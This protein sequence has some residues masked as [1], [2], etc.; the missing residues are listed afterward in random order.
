M[1]IYYSWHNPHLIRITFVW[2][3]NFL[4]AKLFYVSNSSVVL[5]Q[6]CHLLP[7]LSSPIQH[8]TKSNTRTWECGQVWISLRPSSH[9]CGKTDKLHSWALFPLQISV[10]NNTLFWCLFIPLGVLYWLFRVRSTN[11]FAITSPCPSVCLPACKRNNSTWEYI[12]MH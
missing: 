11:M 5:L 6:H 10:L 4:E 12:L 8:G 7:A 3:L 9:A 1:E 2:Q